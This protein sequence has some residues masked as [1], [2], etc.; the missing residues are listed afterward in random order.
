MMKWANRPA[1]FA[2]LLLFTV[3]QPVQSQAPTQENGQSTSQTTT[4]A[5]TQTSADNAGEQ[6]FAQHCAACHEGGDPRAPSLASLNTM[7][8]DDL[9][10]ALTGGVMSAQG[11]SLN[12]S[13][14]AILVEHLARDPVSDNWIAANRC[15]DERMAISLDKASLASPGGGL[16][17]GRQLSASQS[18]LQK[19]N[20]SALEVAWSIADCVHLLL[21][22]KIRFFIQQLPV[23][24]F[25]PLMWHQVVLNGPTMRVLHYEDQRCWVKLFPVSR[26]ISRRCSMSLTNGP[27]CTLLTQLTE[28]RYGFVPEC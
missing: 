24:M 8:A 15:S 13:Q 3:Y 25:L 9:R 14:L 5:V 28:S 10:F 11:Q 19:S 23:P 16:E 22:P 4:Q 1:A 2:L 26:P 27:G 17:F 7:S 18:G 21:L 12:E 20:L 6:L